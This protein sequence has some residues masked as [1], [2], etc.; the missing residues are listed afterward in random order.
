MVDQ[1]LFEYRTVEG[2]T[3]ERG[4]HRLSQCRAECA[5]RE[6]ATQVAIT[7]LTDTAEL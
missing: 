4:Y 1:T 6:Q 3:D 5:G 2:P 7:L